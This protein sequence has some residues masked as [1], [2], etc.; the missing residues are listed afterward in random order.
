MMMIAALATGFLLRREARDAYALI[1]EDMMVDTSKLFAQQLKLRMSKGSSIERAAGEWGSEFNLFRNEEFRIQ[2]LGFEKRR[3]G[4]DVY[5]ADK[6]GRVLFSS[7]PQDPVGADYSNWRDVSL[8]LQGRYGARASRIRTNGEDVVDYFVGSPVLIDGR[9][10]GVVSVI[11]TR[12]SLTDFLDLFMSRAVVALVLALTL[13]IAFGGLMFLWITRPVERLRN[14]ALRVS[15]GESPMLPELPNRELKQ[16]GLAF[17]QMR[18]SVE[19]RKT[20]ER[21]VQSLVHEMK[22]PLSAMRGSAE[23]VLETSMPN[24]QRDR[25]LTNIVEEAHRSEKILEEI[26]RLASVEALSSLETKSRVLLSEICVSAENALLP[27]AAKQQVRFAND[28]GREE[29]SILGDSFL[30]TQALRN[31]LQNAI[32]FSSV[33]AVIAV[34][35]E[36]TARE[37]HVQVIDS[38]SGVPEFAKSRVFEKFFSLERPATGRKG[39]GLGLSFVRDVMRLHGGDASLATRVDTHGTIAELRFPRT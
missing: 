20:I 13:L 37:I 2:I 30:L 1:T 4:I 18:V 12:T 5:I 22:S 35:F 25:F 31:L 15:Q 6:V 3:I 23:L 19:G 11:R 29:V 38:G 27:L 9:V 10:Q 39:S 17:E 16:L 14:Y 21:F 33:G 32:E 8:S 26:L 28:F 34:H 24:D 36:M 7:R